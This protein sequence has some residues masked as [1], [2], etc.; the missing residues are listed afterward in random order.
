MMRKSKRY[1]DRDAQR[2]TATSMMKLFEVW[3]GIGAFLYLMLGVTVDALLERKLHNR[4]VIMEASP[5]SWIGVMSMVSPPST[6]TLHPITR[7]MRSSGRSQRPRPWRG[8]TAFAS[9]P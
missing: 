3:G 4:S 8:I 6:Q 9:R 2:R 5:K 1:I 7:R